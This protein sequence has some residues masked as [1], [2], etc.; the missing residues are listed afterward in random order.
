MGIDTINAKRSEGVADCPRCGKTPQWVIL[1]EDIDHT[2]LMKKFKLACANKHCGEKPE[3]DYYT[4]EAIAI[5]A[6]NG[7]FF[8]VE[9]NK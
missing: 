7:Q 5:S 8:A 4:K 9:A 3:T 2:K 1:A 6:W